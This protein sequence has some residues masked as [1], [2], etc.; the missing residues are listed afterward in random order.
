MSGERAEA[1]GWGAGEGPVPS[2]AHGARPLVLVVE[3]DPDSRTIYRTILRASGYAVVETGDGT[4]GIR[5]ACACEPDLVLLDL[6][7][8]GTNG[9]IV[10]RALRERVETATIP[11]V[12]L[13]AH[14]L[15]EHETRA[16]E[17]GCSAFLS[18]PIAPRE[19]VEEI[20]RILRPPPSAERPARPA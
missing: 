10:T 3:D 7:V 14:V 4:E 9:W 19:I 18:K 15:P 11:V 1:Q 6:D 12:V 20:G 2:A 16:R 5:L 13:T 8:P 17:A